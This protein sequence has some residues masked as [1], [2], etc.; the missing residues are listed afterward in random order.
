M[1]SPLDFLFLKV[2]C[3]TYTL[4]LRTEDSLYPLPGLTYKILK[5]TWIKNSMLGIG[6]D[7]WFLVRLKLRKPVLNFCTF[8]Q[9]YCLFFVTDL[10]F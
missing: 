2:G 6:E 1:T 4:H 3:A 7:E 9:R 10:L 5:I 8:L